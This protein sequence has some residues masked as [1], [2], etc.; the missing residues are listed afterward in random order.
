[1]PIPGATIVNTMIFTTIAAMPTLSNSYLRSVRF[2]FGSLKSVNITYFGLFGS[3]GICCTR[4]PASSSTSQGLDTSSRRGIRDGRPGL[5]PGTSPKQNNGAC[6]PS[7]YIYMYLNIVSIY[8]YTYVGMSVCTNT[9]IYTH[10][11]IMYT[12]R[13]W[14][15]VGLPAVQCRNYLS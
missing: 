3:T 15:R 8:V 5:K 13:T 6:I 11:Y 9:Y 10:T 4:K 1:M 14:G 7:I 2:C 12:S